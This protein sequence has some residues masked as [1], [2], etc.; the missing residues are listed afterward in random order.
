MNDVLNLT[1]V[2]HAELSTTDL[3]IMA[4]RASDRYL[5]QECSLNDAV[6]KEASQHSNISQE[7]IRRVVEKANVET[8]NTI[9]EKQA[10]DKNV[11]FDIAKPEEI[12]EEMDKSAKPQEKVAMPT[13]YAMAPPSWR[14]SSVKADLEI[15]SMFGM[16]P[17]SPAF[18]KVAGNEGLVKEATALW[19]NSGKETLEEELRKMGSVENINEYISSKEEY[20]MAD[21]NRDLVSTHQRLTKLASDVD[22]AVKANKHMVKE[23]MDDLTN[24]VTQALLGGENFGAVVQAMSTLGDVPLVKEAMSVMLPYLRERGLS[25]VKAQVEAISHEMDKTATRIPNP[26]NPI[27]NTFSA[28]KTLM[29]GQAELEKNASLVHDQLDRTHKLVVKAAR[30]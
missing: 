7:Q 22:D 25:P 15:A 9:F 12:L 26:S 8:F 18:E 23:A 21:P 3:D 20:P 4:R 1:Q 14:D 29:D 24:H 16:K 2:K 6:I 27:V 10:G 11:D 17:S 30:R 5:A 19:G 28:L 13:E